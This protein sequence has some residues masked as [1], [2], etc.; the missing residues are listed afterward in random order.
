MAPTTILPPPNLPPI[1]ATPLTP[2]AFHPFGSVI[3]RPPPTTSTTTTTTTTTS[4]PTTVN[5]GTAQKHP[6]VSVIT[7]TQPPSGTPAPINI[8]IFV[9]APRTL[10]GPARNT[11]ACTI[12]ERHPYS[13]QSFIPLAL[14][15]CADNDTASRYL[16]I[17]APTLRDVEGAPPDLEGLRAFV[18]SG[19]QG[20]TYAAGTW[21]AP[22]VALGEVEVQ[23]AVVVAENGVEGEDTQEVGIAGGGV[24]VVVV[25]VGE[26]VGGLWGRTKARF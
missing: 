18:C 17:V 14:P 8:N 23:F 26:G 12:L 2:A 19:V 3:Q 16:V 13:S 25:G 7:T 10:S 22:M 4:T 24:G 15:P 9:C 20:V 21:H 1:T 6:K 5:Q 11:F